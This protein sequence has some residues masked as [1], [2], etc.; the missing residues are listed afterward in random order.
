MTPL[1]PVGYWTDP[2]CIWAFVA[3]PRLDH[4]RG[5]YGAEL[6]LRHHVV[7]VFGS[8]P[9]RF[10]QGPWAAG[11]HAA[12]AEAT[13][14]IAQKHG[15]IGVSGQVWIDDPPASSWPA[16]MAAKAVLALEAQER[17]P[18]GAADAYLWGLRTRFFLDDV[19]MA[20]RSAQLAL[21][22]HLDLPRGLI[23]QAL[24]DGSALAALWEDH[25]EA[26]RL[27]L[28]GSPT[29]VFD[30]GRTLLY[31][32][33]DERVLTATV[34]AMLAGAHAGGSRC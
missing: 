5:A 11:G 19:N 14:T 25:A 34:D 26:E 4:V 28:Q 8:I 9:L 12:R 30:G 29:W 24:D 31:G 2:L 27:H 10:R 32:N 21:A 6:D 3:Q 16:G 22:E 20:R 15:R 1:L 7:P 23:E 18:P 17:V 33:F 13:R